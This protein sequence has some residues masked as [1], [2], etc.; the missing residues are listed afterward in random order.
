MRRTIVLDG[1]DWTV[2]GFVGVDAA[3]SAAARPRAD[4]R[5]GEVERRLRLGG[6]NVGEAVVS[7]P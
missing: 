7:A 6:W 5:P 3:A 4:D 2:E 1:A